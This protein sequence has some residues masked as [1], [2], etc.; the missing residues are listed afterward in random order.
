MATKP[1]SNIGR[2]TLFLR[3]YIKAAAT[4]LGLTRDLPR[5][6]P[7]LRS[8]MKMQRENPNYSPLFR[9][10]KTGGRY[11]WHLNIPGFPSPAFDRIF[12]KWMAFHLGLDPE[13]GL[14]S[15]LMAITTKCHLNCE[16]CYEW[17]AL[18]QPEALDEQEILATVS[19]LIELEAG[20]IV[21]A[22]G[23]PTDRFPTLLRVLDAYRDT[24]VQFWINT[25]GMGLTRERLVQLQ[26]SG[27]TGIVFSLDHYEPREHD[28][29]RGQ[30]GSH[31]Q[32]T[33]MVEIANGLGLVTALSL[34]ATNEFVSEA[35][36]DA[37][38]KLA[39]ELGVGF[40]QILEPK[41]V[42]RYEN[43][44][45]ALTGKNRQ[46]LESFYDRSCLP[47]PAEQ[48]RPILS[49]PDCE[50][51]REGCGGGKW[52]LYVDTHGNAFPCPFCRTKPVSLH[53][54][55]PSNLGEQLACPFAGQ[56]E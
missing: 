12:R 53:A 46:C 34:C 51:R 54:L 50:S 27:L 16:H 31:R 44:Q 5:V 40:V 32:V 1:L 52:Y 21:F 3:L 29:F 8:L 38:L 14:R 39:G 47:C 37:Y 48:R 55:R 7:T 9:C 36:L 28:A 4:V 24:D 18:N 43:C 45:V 41:P 35:N 15:G 10:F 13:P 17:E 42:G 19:R 6:I 49:C 2:K 56:S 26:S 11:Y 33:S 22:G 23:E 25:S 20:Q 30:A